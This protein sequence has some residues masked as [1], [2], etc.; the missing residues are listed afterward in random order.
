[1]SDRQLRSILASEYVPNSA[2]GQMNLIL[3]LPKIY[4][5]VRIAASPAQND[6]CSELGRNANQCNS[7]R[8][9]KVLSQEEWKRLNAKLH[10][11]DAENAKLEEKRLANE[12]LRQ[13]SQEM[14]KH[15][16][17]TFLGSRQKKLDERAKRLADEEAARVAIDIEEA[18]L[19]AEQRK[20]AIEEAKL[21][22]Y[23]QTDQMK[24]LHSA[25]LL[26]EVLQERNAQLELKELCERTKGDKEKVLV[27]QWKRDLAED[28]YFVTFIK[29]GCSPLIEFTGHRMKERIEAKKLEE[30]E[31]LAEREK[32]LRIA[33]EDEEERKR[34]I[35][36]ERELGLDLKSDYKEQMKRNQKMKEI[37]RLKEEEE[38]EQCRIF[39]AAKRKMTTMRVLKER[40]MFKAREEQMEQIKNFLSE[41]LKLKYKDE[42]ERYVRASAEKQETENLR[43]AEKAK[44]LAQRIA[45]INAHRLEEIQRHRKE[46]E[47]EKLAEL[48]ELRIRNEAMR[49]A[50]EYEAACQAD[51]AAKLKALSKEYMELKKQQ[52]D[53]KKLERE[54]EIRLAGVGNKLA[55]KEREIFLDYSKRARWIVYQGVKRHRNGIVCFSQETVQSSL[56]RASIL[57]DQKHESSPD[58]S[59]VVTCEKLPPPLRGA[60]QDMDTQMVAELMSFIDCPKLPERSMQVKFGLVDVDGKTNHVF[61]KIIAN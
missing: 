61:K 22:M 42:E 36:R 49:A 34:F 52:D 5:F 59:K 7:L 54:T 26:T 33:A 58:R 24:Q 53:S 29:R 2:K 8:K 48:E 43:E 46:E 31:K 41:Q 55:Q 14:V 16:T 6:A 17:N 45:E 19:Q 35:Q 21:K 3:L 30:S 32:L 51:R 39:A 37:E 11:D 1:M 47:A 13:T 40:E 57:G 4:L 27:E 23:Y 60:E 9:V 15:W 28:K 12:K 56:P 38:E 44:L 50:N 18:K 25:L 20:A 10:G